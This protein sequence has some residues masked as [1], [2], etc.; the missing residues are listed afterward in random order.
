MCLTLFMSESNK[1][2]PVLKT[3]TGAKQKEVYAQYQGLLL[4]ALLHLEKAYACDPDEQ[5]KSI[6]DGTLKNGGAKAKA[7]EHE[8]RITVM[9]E[10]CVT[11][12]TED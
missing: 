4:E 3:A 5:T 10:N 6:I 12:L 1:L 9:K 7:A 8:Q 2:V 11:I